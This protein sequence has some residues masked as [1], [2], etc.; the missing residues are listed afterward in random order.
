[1]VINVKNTQSADEEEDRKSILETSICWQLKREKGM[2][3]GSVFIEY[4]KQ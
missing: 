3:M 4:T 2:R 1:M